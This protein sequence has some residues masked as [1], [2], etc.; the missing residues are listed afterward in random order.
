MKQSTDIVPGSIVYSMVTEKER[1][2]DGFLSEN[3]LVLQISGIMDVE[4]S[5]EKFSTWPGDMLLTRK[6]QL[7]KITK[8]PYNG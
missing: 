7:A 4:T 2:W 8:M 6:H 5:T 3:I 1:V